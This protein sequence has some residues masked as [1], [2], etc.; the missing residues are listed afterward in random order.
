[1]R[2]S[3]WLLSA[4]LVWPCGAARAADP[5]AATTVAEAREFLER[6]NAALLACHASAWDID[7]DT[8]L[9]IK[10]CIHIDADNFT[11]VHTQNRSKTGWRPVN[12][13]GR[14]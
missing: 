10:M 3:A 6:V 7:A 5:P 11:T 13:L 8:D 14:S 9:R 2:P 12:L 4:V 1:M